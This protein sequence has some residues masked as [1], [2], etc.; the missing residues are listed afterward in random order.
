MFFGVFAILLGVATFVLLDQ[1]AFWAYAGEGK[2]LLNAIYKEGP[3]GYQLI[4]FQE[5]QNTFM[6]V[7]N[8]FLIIALVFCGLMML[9]SLLNLIG[10]AAGS[11]RLVGAKFFSIMFFLT[12]AVACVMY[13]MFMKD[14]TNASTVAEILERGTIGYGLV[15]AFGASLLAL[16]FSPRRKKNFKK[17][18]KEE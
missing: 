1:P 4:K 5:G 17:K 18:K 12:M 6:M 10:R 14:S 13:V 11:N 9:F 16:I 2:N 15:A 7:G 8:I 3:S